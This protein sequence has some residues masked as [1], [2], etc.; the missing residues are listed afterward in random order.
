[1]GLLCI[2]RFSD[3]S[4][5][6]ATKPK[7][8]VATKHNCLLN[9]LA[10]FPLEEHN[11]YVIADAVSDASYAMLCSYVPEENIIRTQYK[12]GALSFLHAVKMVA[13]TAAM[14]HAC[15]PEN[16]AVYLVEDDYVHVPDA[17]AAIVEGLAVSDYVTLYDHPDKT[18]AWGRVEPGCLV[19]RTKSSYWKT[20]HSTT[21]TFATTVRV[22]C[23]DFETYTKHCHT[24]YPN[25]HEMFLE[26]GQRAQ[27]PRR[28]IHSI[29]GKA[30]HAE[31]MWL[32]PLVSW[33]GVMANSLAQF[34]RAAPRAMVE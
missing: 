27:H 30:T 10:C 17:A 7:M 5:T 9:F 11:V 3:E 25:D 6:T 14:G 26:L 23:E 4:Q 33:E 29:P 1:M 32:S 20:T 28:L 18:D 15:L 21:M 24:G 19:Y 31:K 34:K 22:L 12:S 2:Y 16:G 8:D 13:N